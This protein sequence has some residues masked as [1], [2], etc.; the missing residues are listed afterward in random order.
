MAAAYRQVFALQIAAYTSRGVKE[1]S[2]PFCMA[3]NVAVDRVEAP[4][5]T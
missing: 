1:S 5:F 4:I 2:R 3:N